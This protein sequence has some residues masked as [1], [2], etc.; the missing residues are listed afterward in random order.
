MVLMYASKKVYLYIPQPGYRC[1]AKFGTCN[2]FLYL[3]CLSQEAKGVMHAMRMQ[4]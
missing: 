2:R 1:E 4:W 3:A